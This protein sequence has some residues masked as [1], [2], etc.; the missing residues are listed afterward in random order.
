MYLFYST[1][2]TTVCRLIVDLTTILKNDFVTKNSQGNLARP[3]IR[4][5]V[6]GGER[7]NFGM[8]ES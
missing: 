3:A 5:N 7:R 2:G 1:Y 4:N 6:D 8:P